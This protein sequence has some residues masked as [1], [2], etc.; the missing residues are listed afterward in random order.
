MKLFIHM[1]LTLTLV[2]IVSGGALSLVNTWAQ[3]KIAANELAEKL[4]GV[5]MVVPGYADSVTL[6]TLLGLS[7]EDKSI[8]EAWKVLGEDGEHIGWALVGVGNGF[9]DKVHLM[10]GLTPDLGRSLG[11]KI[12]KD[13]ETPGLG[14]KIREGKYPAQYATGELEL[15]DGLKC[16]KRPPEAVHEVEA[17]TGATISSVAVVDI[18][19][20]AVLDLK[21]ALE[22]EPIPASTKEAV[23]EGSGS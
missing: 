23:K 8:P 14:T 22:R 18:I 3:P 21:A 5:E 20:A 7:E 9:Q 12:L 15:A 13:S 1:F 10:V 11:L 4:A 6:A 17:I 19:N 2:G 16:V